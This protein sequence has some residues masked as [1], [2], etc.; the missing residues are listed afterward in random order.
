[1]RAHIFLVPNFPRCRTDD[2]SKLKQIADDLGYDLEQDRMGKNKDRM[3]E[4]CFRKHVGQCGEMAIIGL[5]AAKK[6]LFTEQPIAAETNVEMY[7]IEE[8]NHVFLVFGR[9]PKTNPENP[10]EWN[11]EAVICDSW[12]GS[13]FPAS[14]HN[15]FLLRCALKK[16]ETYHT[17]V[18]PWTSPKE[19]PSC[20]LHLYSEKELEALLPTDAMI[21]EVR[22]KY[23]NPDY[24][25]VL[26]SYPF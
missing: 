23:M 11:S 19:G 13:F 3:F 15:R 10:D 22:K 7:R 9:D 6:A 20:R 24:L 18:A 17:L 21:S 16:T 14:L 26:A 5:V 12:S 25:R 1:M 8:G 2:L 4:A